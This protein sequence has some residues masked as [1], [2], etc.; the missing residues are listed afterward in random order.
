MG[1]SDLSQFIVLFIF[2]E[3]ASA[4]G[5]PAFEAQNP[6]V[7]VYESAAIAIDS[8]PWERYSPRKRDCRGRSSGHHVLQWFV[9]LPKY[10]DWWWFPH[11]YLQP[12]HSHS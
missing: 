5:N 11:D 2:S 8:E 3:F 4:T 12:V 10:G 6:Q 9:Q 1:R 7:G